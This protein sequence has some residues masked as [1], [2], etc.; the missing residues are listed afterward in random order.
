MNM[1]RNRLRRDQPKI[2]STV[3]TFVASADP[4]YLDAEIVSI[5]LKQSNVQTIDYVPDTRTHRL[6]L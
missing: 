1:K 6:Q 2:G 5:M 4:I 3:R